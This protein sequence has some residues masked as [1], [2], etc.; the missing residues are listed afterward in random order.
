MISKR[1][2]HLFRVACVTLCFLVGCGGSSGGGGGS[3]SGGESS[4]GGGG[5]GGGGGS[6]SGTGDTWVG[7]AEAKISGKDS[8]EQIIQ[9]EITWTADAQQPIAGQTAYSGRGK[10]KFHTPNCVVTPAETS[11][12][13]GPLAKLVI[14]ST[15]SPATY[16]AYGA[17]TWTATVNC[18][19]VLPVRVPRHERPDDPECLAPGNCGGSGGEI[20]VGGVWLA[21]YAT[22]DK[23]VHGSV[24]PNATIE[25]TASVGDPQ[26]VEYSFQWSFRKGD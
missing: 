23:A 22:P 20:L 25:G 10:A 6:A 18:E 16:M 21:D 11:I 24:S 1:P 15:R 17:S 19:V 5:G 2:M 3:G 9:V 12:D 26:S 14:D 4:G 8:S 13:P 7:T